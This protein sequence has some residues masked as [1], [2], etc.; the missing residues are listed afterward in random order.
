MAKGVPWGRHT[1][2]RQGCQALGTL[3]ISPTDWRGS[4]CK[5]FGDALTSSHLKLP[6]RHSLHPTEIPCPLSCDKG[7]KIFP[8]PSLVTHYAIW[9]CVYSSLSCPI[10]SVLSPRAWSTSFSTAS[11]R[12]YKQCLTRP[13]SG[14]SH[15]VIPS[16]FSSEI[17]LSS[18][19][20]ASCA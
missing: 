14:G 19:T 9:R 4:R 18:A 12:S 3:S 6:V 16:T 10:Y 13:H 20:C 1:Q 11:G 7:R 2:P 17:E 15:T 5:V 8:F